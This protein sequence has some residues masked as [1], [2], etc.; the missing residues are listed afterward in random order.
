MAADDREV[1]MDA[2]AIVTQQIR[3]LRDLTNVSLSGELL[4][5]IRGALGARE[6]RRTL[7]NA[8]LA[9]IDAR[10]ALEADGYPALDAIHI[11]PALS[12]EL[13]DELSDVGAAAGIFDESAVA[14]QII[15]D[16]GSPSDKPI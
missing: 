3:G 16:L 5:I 7:I 4:S 6:H 10:A 12:A 2:L 9:S 13:R 1:L 14:S 11:P 15:V 8:V